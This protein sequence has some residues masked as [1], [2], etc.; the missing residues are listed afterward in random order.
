MGGGRLVRE[1]C[2]N[3]KV[4]AILGSWQDRKACDLI[5]RPVYM[6]LVFL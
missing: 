5:T 1:V 3:R 4:V 2:V 6:G